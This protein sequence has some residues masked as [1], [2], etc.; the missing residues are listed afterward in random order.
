M[1]HETNPYKVGD[2]V[3]LWCDDGIRADCTVLDVDGDRCHI[4][5]QRGGPSWYYWKHFHG[6]LTKRKRRTI[7]VNEYKTGFG[8]IFP[9]K[10]CAESFVADGRIRT[11]RFVEAKGDGK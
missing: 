2:R 4:K 1:K 10:A 8:P 11:I 7:W 9:T 3:F 6:R 5:S